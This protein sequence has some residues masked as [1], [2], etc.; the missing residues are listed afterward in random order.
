MA[1]PAYVT[2]P[3]VLYLHQ[4]LEELAKGYLQI[5]QFQRDFVWTDE[6]RLELLQSVRSGIPIGSILVWRTGITVLKTVHRIGPHDLPEPVP[7]P[8]SA[9][10]YLLDGLQRMSTLF[11]CL[12]PLAPG[13]SPFVEAEDGRQTS[14]LVGFDLITEQFQI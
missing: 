2:D 13:G 4:L 6:Q 9:R 14:W 5:P 1:A 12:R 10:S 11:G 8:T 3:T 7:S